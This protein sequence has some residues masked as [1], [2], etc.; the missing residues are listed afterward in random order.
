MCDPPSHIFLYMY[1]ECRDEV[2]ISEVVNKSESNLW[3]EALHKRE[4]WY[5]A[6]PRKHVTDITRSMCNTK[7]S[8]P[9]LDFTKF[10]FASGLTKYLQL[11][12]T[13]LQILFCL[14]A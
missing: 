8:I 7:K 6:G 11:Q 10:V 12:R 3:T 2:R 9:S 14:K 4:I 5:Q 1:L 13:K